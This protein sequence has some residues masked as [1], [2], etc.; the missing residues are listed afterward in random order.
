[1]TG[2]SLDLDALRAVCVAC[3]GNCPPD[4]DAYARAV[5]PGIVLALVEYVEANEAYTANSFLVFECRADSASLAAP[6][7]RFE[8]ARS[9]LGLTKE[10]SDA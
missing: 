6:L 1:M 9:A 10:P 4:D 2:P 3:R 5:D 8:A 7:L